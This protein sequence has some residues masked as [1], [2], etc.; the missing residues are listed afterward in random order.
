MTVHRL[1]KVMTLR[2][3]NLEFTKAF[4]MFCVGFACEVLHGHVGSRTPT[5]PT[6]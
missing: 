3:S 4:L 5:G 1:D 2:S 6:H